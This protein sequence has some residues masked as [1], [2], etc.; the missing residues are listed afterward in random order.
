MSRL[1]CNLPPQPSLV[2]WS[3]AAAA[4]DSRSC[5]YAR[6]FGAASRVSVQYLKAEI[7]GLIRWEE[8]EELRCAVLAHRKGTCRV[9]LR[10][11]AT[12]DSALSGRSNPTSQICFPQR[13]RCFGDRDRDPQGR[14][15]A[16][17][18]SIDH[19]GKSAAGSAFR[20]LSSSLLPARM[21]SHHKSVV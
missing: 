3:P 16:W 8:H 6:C 5:K 12:N 20:S 21:P 4:V 10:T 15:H 19:V 18:A 11:F 7:G 17:T 9:M 14:G 1:A 13:T 2:L